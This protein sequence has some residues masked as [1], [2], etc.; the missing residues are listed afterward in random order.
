VAGDRGLERVPCPDPQPRLEHGPK[1]AALGRGERDEQLILLLAT[2]PLDARAAAARRTGDHAHAV[3]LPAI[4]EER[5]VAHRTDRGET[6]RH[7]RLAGEMP[8]Q[9]GLSLG[10]ERL[11]QRTGP[12][13]RDPRPGDRG[14]DAATRVDRHPETTGP[15]G[16]PERIREVTAG[17]G[18]ASGRLDRGAAAVRSVGCHRTDRAT[19]TAARPGRRR[20][21][22]LGAAGAGAAGDRQPATG[23]PAPG[24][25]TDP[26]RRDPLLYSASGRMGL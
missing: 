9:P 10:E 24:R 21:L 22:S 4:A 13:L 17:Q 7:G 20:R 1:R 3:G 14:D 6:V 18:R 15:V 23:R 19:G 2:D 12:R 11:H 5:A 26:A 25:G 16:P 8:S